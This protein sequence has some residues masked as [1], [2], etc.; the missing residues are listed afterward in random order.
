M[1]RQTSWHNETMRK[2]YIGWVSGTA[3]SEFAVK[4]T[5]QR[6]GLYVL[7]RLL[8]FDSRKFCEA[9]RVLLRFAMHFAL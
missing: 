1:T 8:P 4:G 2:L 7:R 9:V 5:L 3:L 6:L